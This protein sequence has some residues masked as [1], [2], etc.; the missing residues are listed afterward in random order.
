MMKSPG[1]YS[2]KALIY[3]NRL[4]YPVTVLGKGKR[5]GIWFQG[6]SIKCPGCIN[7]DL[8]EKDEDSALTQKQ[9][10]DL[11]ASYQD[12]SPDGITITGGEPFDQPYGLMQIITMA[13][14]MNLGEVLVYSGYDFNYLKKY[15][16]MI[17]KHIDILISGPFI[18]SL[19]TK[20]IW[21]GSDN[22]LIHLLSTEAMKLYSANINELEYEEDHRPIQFAF[23]GGSLFIIG[24]PRRGDLEKLKSHCNNKGIL[25]HGSSKR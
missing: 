19:P 11:L 16:F 10:Y 13:K 12:K 4:H 21:R 24:I 6:C 3:I 1:L 2:N 22:Q 5:L 15:F 18:E 8:Q 9:A 23:S 17:L 7:E 20:K 25:L 14:S